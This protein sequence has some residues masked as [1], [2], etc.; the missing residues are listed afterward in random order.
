MG[1]RGEGGRRKG[2]MWIEESKAR[3]ARSQQ[4]QHAQH[5]QHAGAMGS[6]SRAG[7]E[8]GGHE[9]LEKLADA[10]EQLKGAQGEGAQAGKREALRP[11]GRR[12]VFCRKMVPI[13][14]LVRGV[15]EA[16]LQGKINSL[17]DDEFGPLLQ[18]LC[19]SCPEQMMMASFW[20]RPDADDR[21]VAMILSTPEFCWTKIMPKD[22]PDLIVRRKGCGYQPTAKLTTMLLGEGAEPPPSKPVRE[23]RIGSKTIPT[24]NR[25][26]AEK[27]DTEKD[28]TPVESRET[29]PEAKPVAESQELHPHPWEVRMESALESLGTSKE[30]NEELYTLFRQL[31]EL[32]EMHKREL[33]REEALMKKKRT[34]ERDLMV[35]LIA[36]ERRLLDDLK[37]KNDVRESELLQAISRNAIA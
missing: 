15:D 2:G 37:Q 6:G 25:S 27:S 4:A 22:V 5:A 3:K 35:G 32:R 17:K 16:Y 7:A 31:N 24:Q 23:R 33:I 12:R 21:A 13:A 20:S 36:R 10:A 28:P 1:V 9:T 26:L 18:H 14:K 34:Y 8:E 29:T 30:D 19:G 11:A